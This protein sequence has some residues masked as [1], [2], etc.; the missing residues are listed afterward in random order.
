MYE[1]DI[2]GIALIFVVGA[3]VGLL[4]GVIVNKPSGNR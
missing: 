4:L 1:I 2:Q 3:L